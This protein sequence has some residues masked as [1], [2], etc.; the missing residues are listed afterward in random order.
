M[1]TLLELSGVPIIFDEDQERLRYDEAQMHCRCSQ[2]VRLSDISPTLLNKSLRYPEDVYMHHVDVIPR[3]QLADW[4]TTYHYD[5]LSI[6]VG[7]LG[8][9]YV[10]THVFDT[11]EGRGSQACVVEVLRGALTVL[12]Q[13]NFPRKDIFDIETKV[14]DVMLIKVSTGEKLA[15]PCGYM[16]TFVNAEMVPVVFSRVIIS[17]HVLDY[18]RIKRENGL[19]YYLIA[20]NAR[21]ETVANP[22]YRQLAP[23]KQINISE[24]NDTV[25]YAPE[26]GMSLYDEVVNLQPKFAELFA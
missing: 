10:K 22:R 5:I 12:L 20:K 17:E 11:E 1:V 13:K 2:S 19:A 24:L 23:V 26:V 4:P 7:L 8:I 21:L 14:S 18:Q 6:P 15:I 25:N 9:E 16:Y 3:N